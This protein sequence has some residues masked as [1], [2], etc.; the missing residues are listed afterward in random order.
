MIF[1]GIG[2]KENSRRIGKLVFSLL[3]ICALCS[4]VLSAGSCADQA[5]V[6]VSNIDE[7]LAAIA[8]S[9]E[10]RLEKGRYYF[11]EAGTYGNAGVSDY[12]RWDETYDGYELVITG[13]NDLTIIGTDDDDVILSAE[14]RYSNV[15]TFENCA[16]IYISELT[17][18]HTVEPGSCAGGVV[19]LNNT[20]DFTASECS[21]YG[22]GILGL[23]AFSSKNILM[24]D[25]EIYDCSD[26]AVVLNNC[27]NTEFNDCEI[28][29]CGRNDYYSFELFRFDTCTDIRVLNCEIERNRASTVLS[30]GHSSDVVFTG[31]EVKKNVITEGM[32]S[33]EK[34]GTVIDGCKFIDNDTAAWYQNSAVFAV[35]A[36]GDPLAGS[37]FESMRLDENIRVEKKIASPLSNVVAD[38]NGYIHVTNV[39]ELLSA[40]A[41]GVSILLE[42]ENFNLSSAYNY[43][44]YGGEYYYWDECYDGPELVISGCDGLSIIGNPDAPENVNIIAFPRYANVLCFEFCNDLFLS[45]FTAGHEQTPGDCSGGVLDFDSCGNITVD[46]CRLYGCGV[47]G[48]TTYNCASVN[49]LDTEIYDCTYGGVS[50]Y[51]TDG[52]SFSGCSI[53]DVGGPM[54]SF[55]DTGDKLW[56]GTPIPYDGYFDIV[57]SKLVE[58]D[59]NATY[60]ESYEDVYYDSYYPDGMRNAE[61]GEEFPLGFV[62]DMSWT[63]VT[64]VF[65]V[66]GPETCNKIM[67][68]PG[69]LPFEPDNRINAWA[70]DNGWYSRLSSEATPD[71][72]RPRSMQGL[73]QPFLIDIYYSAQFGSDG[74]PIF[75]NNIPELWS[76]TEEEINGHRA[77]SF[78]AFYHVDSAQ[79]YD[80]YYNYI[81]LFNEEQGYMIVISGQADMQTLKDIAWSLEV[82]TLDEQV[83][84]DDFEGHNVLIDCAVG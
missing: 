14:P 62:E 10:I 77:I 19:F 73:S 20:N 55:M 24:N 11:S 26:G 22:C 27:R 71:E 69:W 41:P 57:D 36:Q 54:L 84:Y 9:T 25:C 64:T 82:K 2:E 83:S 35:N 45:G 53:H 48:I 17:A 46:S 51:Q 56:D 61:P 37:D 3:L 15:L 52:I 63:N 6:T 58:Y 76:V 74:H 39:D 12:Y 42:G 31:N 33:L 67:F 72:D 81:L 49:V 68:R 38:E 40:I 60:D 7:F 80:I 8:P 1:T 23:Q 75:L 4:A 59:W 44:S 13:V 21:F 28:R 47:M 50:I 29:T 34:Q 43:G 70:E 78:E 79:P 5:V 30:T 16:N 65:D 18:G 66:P 32:F